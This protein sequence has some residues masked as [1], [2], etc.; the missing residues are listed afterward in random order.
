MPGAPVP[1]AKKSNGCLVAV[2]V[3]AAVTLLSCLVGGVVL[4]R[5][6]KDPEV[7]KVLNA[8]G[9]GAKLAIEGSKAPGAEE[10]RKAGCPQAIIMDGRRM[11][12]LVSKFVDAG[13]DAVPSDAF[14]DVVVLCQGTS[15]KD[16][17]P[18][19][20]QAALVYAQAALP[21]GPFRVIVSRP[22]TGDEHGND[23]EGRYDAMGA[24]LPDAPPEEELH[25]GDD[26]GLGGDDEPPPDEAPTPAPEAPERAR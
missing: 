18:G 7:M 3:V 5:V 17:L 25:E 22:G 24:A 21:A 11:T 4:W 10:L 14:A 6:S 12:E 20:D 23:C 26:P 9:E 1:G 19:C 13:A 15:A 8:V 2:A 16:T